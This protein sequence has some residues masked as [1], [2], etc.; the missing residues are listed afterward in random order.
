MK[1]FEPPRDIRGMAIAHRCDRCGAEPG[2]FC[3]P[4]DNEPVPERGIIS[5]HPE[6]LE[7][8]KKS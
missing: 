2:Y 8:A 5:P 3:T 7:A 1:P 6:R 4:V